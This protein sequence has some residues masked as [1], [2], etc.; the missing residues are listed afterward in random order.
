MHFGFLQNVYTSIFL[1]NTCGGTRLNALTVISFKYLLLAW[2][3]I[4]PVNTVFV[5]KKDKPAWRPENWLWKKVKTKRVIAQ[6]LYNY[7][8]CSEKERNYWG[9][10]NQ[11]LSKETKTALDDKD[12]L[13]LW[14]KTHK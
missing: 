9:T 13:E 6:V 5:V 11:T 7:V 14:R 1:R 4:S 8:K 12:I 10:N 3:W 2:L